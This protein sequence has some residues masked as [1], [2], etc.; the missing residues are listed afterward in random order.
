MPR[1]NELLKV[2]HKV[3]PKIAR[4]PIFKPDILF[5]GS[6]FNTT[7]NNSEE[8]GIHLE[9]DFSEDLM[10]KSDSVTIGEISCPPQ[11]KEDKACILLGDEKNDANASP[12]LVDTLGLLYRH[13]LISSKP[14]APSNQLA[15]K[16]RKSS[17]DKSDDGTYCCDNLKDPISSKKKIVKHSK[18]LGSP[19]ADWNYF[20]LRRACFRGMS[21]YY[22]ERFNSFVKNSGLTKSLKLEMDKIVSRFIEHEFASVHTGNCNISNTEFLDCMITVLHSHRHK[23]NED[24]IRRRDFTKIR[25]VLYSFSTAAKKTFLSCP[26]YALVL[27]NFFNRQG[28]DFLV[29]KSKLKPARFR[30]ELELELKTLNKGAVQTL[31]F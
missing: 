25:Q 26:N 7:K 30:Q 15:S 5:D 3:F 31:G 12:M 23:K 19:N 29:K 20:S 14:E 22:K 9:Q 28:E 17:F 1:E 16:D 10:D 8:K 27:N 2:E 11:E 24:Y 18:T 6:I 13:C 21:A 4:N